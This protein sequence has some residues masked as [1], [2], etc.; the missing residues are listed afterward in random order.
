[1]RR[2]IPIGLVLALVVTGSAFAG[3][4]ECAEKA[5]V[6]KA[7]TCTATAEECRQHMTEMFRD[8]GWVGLELDRDEEGR[9]VR[10]S[11]VEPG[12]PASAA[13]FQV[14]DELVAL[15]GVKLGEEN[16]HKVYA[17]KD[18]LV[19]GARV[20]Y[21]VDRGGVKLDL[22]VT[23]AQMPQDVLAAWIDRHMASDHSSATAS[24]SKVAEY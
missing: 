10:V 22:P 3:G 18:K 8:R 21:T 6:A 5:R 1:M 15:N 16:Q 7:D 11:R 2:T 23:L 19:V 24:A 20:T 9:A 17:A 12:S 4:A 13:G 14:G